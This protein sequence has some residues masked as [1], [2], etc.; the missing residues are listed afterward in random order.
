MKTCIQ[1]A[2]CLAVALAAC[3]GSEARGEYLLGLTSANHLLTFSGDGPGS[4]VADVPVTN[5]AA[6]E[7]LLG[8]DRR[9]A[10]AQIYALGSTNTIYVVDRFTGVATAV[11][12]GP[13][14]ALSGNSFGFDFNPAADRIRVVSDAGQN[15]R[16]NPIGGAGGLAAADAT[17]AF[18][19][20]DVNAARTPHVVELAYTNSKPVLGPTTLYGIDSAR[21]VLVR[22]G[23]DPANAVVGDPGNPNSGVVTTIGALGVATTDVVGFDVSGLT[24]IAYASLTPA[25]GGPSRLYTINLNTGAATLVGTIGSGFTITGLTAAVPEPGGVVLLGM[26]LVGLVAV[27][28]HSRRAGSAG[29]A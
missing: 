4:V 14:F 9:P 7:T 29:R 6:G 8:I 18:A 11:T 13:A 2:R 1:F 5:L 25:A 28:G 20:G 26:G 19:A 23:A 12:G 21:G 15:L 16:L 27:R 17:L 10:T 24:G 3:A 22:I